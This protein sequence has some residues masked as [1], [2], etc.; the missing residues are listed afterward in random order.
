MPP[1]FWGEKTLFEIVSASNCQ[2]CGNIENNC[3]MLRGRPYMTSRN[4]GE[5]LT[6]SPIASLFGNKA[7]VLSSQNI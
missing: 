5:I 1:I 6:P 4:S 2:Q 3:L 7:L